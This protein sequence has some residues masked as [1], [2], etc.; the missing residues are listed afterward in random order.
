M[1]GL[2]EASDS[3]AICR[4][5]VPDRALSSLS[6]TG[7]GGTEHMELLR[8]YIVRVYRQQ[9]GGI[10]GVVE[11]VETGDAAAFRSAEELW[12]VLLNPVPMRR[13]FP[14]GSTNEEGGR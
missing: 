5:S 3:I 13:S 1:H 7:Y 12:A 6:H 10:T 2:I 9:A 8:S 11:S 4:Q 14:P